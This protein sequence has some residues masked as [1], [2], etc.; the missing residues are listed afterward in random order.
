MTANVIDPAQIGAAEEAGLR[1]QRVPRGAWGMAVGAVAIALAVFYLLTSQIGTFTPESHRGV[2]WGATA[3][4]VF[5]LYPSRR[6]RQRERPTVLDWALATGTALAAAYIVQNY[7]VL[8]ERTPELTQ[9]ETVLGAFAIL[10]SLEAA[11]RT[12]GWTLPVIATV[13]LIYLFAGPAL[14][15]GMAHRGYDLPRIV[16][17]MYASLDGILGIISYTFATYVFLFMVFGAVLTRTGAGQFMVDLPYA[18]AGSLRGGPA[19]VAIAMSALMASVSG[20]AIANVMTTGIYSIP[21]MKR[22][23]YR[24][25]FAGGVEAAASVGGQML[26]PI[27]GAGAFLIAEFTRTPYTTV[28]L[29]SI[30]PGLLYFLIVYLLV[31]FEAAKKDLERVPRAELESPWA[32]FTRGWFFLIPIAVIFVLIILRYSPAYAAFWG[33][34][35]ALL[36]GFLPYQGTRL[37]LPH[38]VGAL[39]DGSLNALGISAVI[40]TLGIVIASVNLTGVG[41]RLSDVIVSAAGGSLLLGLVLVTLASWILGLGLGVTASYIIVAVLAAPALEDLGVSLLVAHLIIFWVA[42]DANV[43]PPICLAAFASASIAG[44]SG[45]RTGYEAWKLSRGLYIVPLLMAYSPLIDGPW[46]AALLPF[47]T[48]VV[49]IWGLCVGLSGYLFR[50]L[51]LAK[52]A[53]F[54]VSG[55]LMIVPDPRVSAAGLVVLAAA[56]LWERKA[57]R[58]TSAG[59]PA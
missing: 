6:G 57:G 2:F 58:S 19:K 43:T 56:V 35:T 31:D 8:I 4:L 37:R 33:I 12:I 5:L 54:G 29:V 11:R 55:G 50:D 32:V 1:V 27:M 51:G 30:V 10:A 36:V 45:M 3:G 59:I 53:V 7:R 46:H 40:G 17:T 20:S 24:K 9:L 48:A 41:L 52:R 26:P 13:A 22:V 39:R 28:A 38:I 16:S 21:L 23:G 49:G 34:L 25:E 18:L 15:A 44:G 14:P 47:L 42:Q